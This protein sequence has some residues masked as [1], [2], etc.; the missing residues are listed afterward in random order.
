MPRSNDPALPPAWVMILASLAIGFHLFCAGVTTLAF[1]SGPWPVPGGEQPVDVATAPYF[2]AISNQ[3]ALPYQ[4]ALKATHSF[5]FPSTRQE[6]QD[7]SMEAVLRDSEGKPVK[8]LSFPNK[9]VPHQ[10]Y[11]R[12]SM[13]M[14]QLA[15]D[16]PLP[17]QGAIVLPGAGQALPT[18]RWWHQESDTQFVLKKDN[19]NA[20]P[21]NQRLDQP[22]NAQFLLVNSFARFI[23]RNNEKARVEVIRLWQPPLQPFIL[24]NRDIDPAPMLRR[25]QSSY[26]ELSQ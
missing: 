7:V 21:R 15:S 2:A 26:G 18:V 10:I 16:I 1:E 3:V 22:S 4:R 11:A 9:D 13:L 8:R 17:P 25:N 14:H 6:Q 12:Q 24:L 23:S 20:V 5:H 19:P